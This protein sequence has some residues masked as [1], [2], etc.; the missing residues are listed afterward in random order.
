MSLNADDCD[1]R[2]T[3]LESSNG[4]LTN[5]LK[6]ITDNVNISGTGPTGAMIPGTYIPPEDVIYEHQIKFASEL[7]DYAAITY[8]TYP[9]I[10]DLG[11]LELATYDNSMEPIYCRQYNLTPEKKICPRISHLR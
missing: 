7:T 1:K 8:R 9:N 3:E 11:E 2:L 4:K 10:G 6:T 5:T